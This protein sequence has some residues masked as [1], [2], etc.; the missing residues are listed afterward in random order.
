MKKIVPMINISKYDVVV[1]KFP[2]A[3]STKYK[4]RPAVIISSETYNKNARET[5]LIMAISSKTDTALDFEY[6]LDDWERAGLLKSS[7][8]KAAIA[9]IEQEYII[10]K[11]GVLSKMDVKKLQE[12]IDKIC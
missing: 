6:T 10:S 9:T 2:F 3:S 4:A 8:F 7:V 1:V 11:I 5:A 12:V